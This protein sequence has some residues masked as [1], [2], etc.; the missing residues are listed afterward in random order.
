M[1]HKVTNANE[2][3]KALKDHNAEKEKEI[4]RIV[5]KYPY[6]DSKKLFKAELEYLCAIAEKQ[7]MERM[8]KIINQ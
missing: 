2:L 8:K 4:K 5:D 3:K 7:E 1:K 6:N